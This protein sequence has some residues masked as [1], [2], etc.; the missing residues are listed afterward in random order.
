MH[1][2]F[3]FCLSTWYIHV[4]VYKSS[5]FCSQVFCSVIPNSTLKKHSRGEKEKPQVG[6]LSDFLDSVSSYTIVALHFKNVAISMLYC[7]RFKNVHLSPNIGRYVHTTNRGNK[8]KLLFP[9]LNMFLWKLSEKI[10]SLP[11][12]LHKWTAVSHQKITTDTNG[13]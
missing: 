3:F 1:Y 6:I 8:I 7:S 9:L 13:D 11:C 12:D 4:F 2:C 5:L 10:H